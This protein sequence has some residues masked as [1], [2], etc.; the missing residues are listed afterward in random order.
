MT[1]VSRIW[2]LP[3]GLKFLEYSSGEFARADVQATMDGSFKVWLLSVGNA[4][5]AVIGLVRTSLVSPWRLWMLVCEA[6]PY[7][8]REALRFLRRW[9][10]K[11]RHSVARLQMLIEVGKWRNERFAGFFGF[12]PVGPAIVAGEAAYREWR[13][14]WPS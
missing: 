3:A 6:F 10:R 8:H 14:A 1:R 4:P 9:L 2:E 7:F 12:E 5:V 11:A 13:S